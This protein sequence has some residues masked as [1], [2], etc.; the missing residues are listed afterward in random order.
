MKNSPN[1]VTH[2]PLGDGICQFAALCYALRELGIY[3]SPDTLGVEVVQFIEEHDMVDDMHLELFT[4]LSW[5][6]YLEETSISGTYGDEIILR[7]MV[8]MFNFEIVVISTLGEGV[9]V[10]ITPEEL[11]PYHTLVICSTFSGDTGKSFWM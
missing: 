6:Q 9:R 1:V 3:R 4:G 7:A 2:D 5:R 11:I 8:N 10:I